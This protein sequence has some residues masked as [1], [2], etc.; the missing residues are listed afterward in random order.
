MDPCSKTSALVMLSVL[1]GFAASMPTDFRPSH[2]LDLN[3]VINRTVCPIEVKINEDPARIP[4]KIKMLTCAR[5]VNQW[6]SEMNVPKNE[7]CHH[8]HDTVTL[9][10]V[11][12]EDVVMV[13][14]PKVNKSQAIRVS[15]GCVC[16]MQ[17]SFKVPD[18]TPNR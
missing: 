18:A 8:Q 7:C 10:C 13:Y 9:S 6:C 15:V 2:P 3:I 1:A 17:E 11:E 16:A 5:D 14:F 12:V 4:Q